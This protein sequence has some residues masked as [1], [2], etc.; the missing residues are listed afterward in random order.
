MLNLNRV[1]ASSLSARGTILLLAL[2]VSAYGIAVALSLPIDVLP[3]L[4]RPT[5]TILTE[6]HGMVPEDVERLVTRPIE[7]SVNGATGV[8]R[9]RSSSGLGLSVVHRIV[10]RVG[11]FVHVESAPGKGST[12]RV[13]LPRVAAPTRH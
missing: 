6:A 9:V 8:E 11:G 5:V 7:Q 2:A 3:D 1:I 4:N 12:F 13:Y 10:D